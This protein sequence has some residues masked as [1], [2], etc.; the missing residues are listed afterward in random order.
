M[1]SSGFCAHF[2][3]LYALC[4]IESLQRRS[5]NHLSRS[6]FSVRRSS[7]TT[8]SLTFRTS[9]LHHQDGLQDH[10]FPVSLEILCLELFFLF[11]AVV[12]LF[13]RLVTGRPLPCRLLLLSVPSASRLVADARQWLLKSRCE[14]PS[15]QSSSAL[16]NKHPAHWWGQLL[17][18]LRSIFT[19]DPL[20]RAL[21]P[22]S[23]LRGY[24]DCVLL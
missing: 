7:C 8:A 10:K 12:S 20:T 22:S 24:P 16:H 23:T 15:P 11:G 3:R 5:F 2:L 13:E 21:C 18:P 1:T 9:L 17:L 19:I 14:P 6:S 4:F